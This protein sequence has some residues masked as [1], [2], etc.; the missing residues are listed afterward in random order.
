MVRVIPAAISFCLIATTALAQAP[1]IKG[2]W[3]GR[4]IGCNELIITI[5]SQT[6]NGVIEGTMNCTKAQ[7]TGSFGE[8]MEGRQGAGKFDGK[9]LSLE[10]ASGSFTRV[11]LENGKFVGSTG[12]TLPGLGPTGVTFTR[13]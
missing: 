7:L 8:K 4:T 2:R 12:S 10:F 1:D 6:P 11:A 3:Q 13:Q 5:T 9:N